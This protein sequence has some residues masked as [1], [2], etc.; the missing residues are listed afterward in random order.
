MESG[1]ESFDESPPRWD[2]RFV[3]EL[4][5]PPELPEPLPPFVFL[6]MKK[7]YREAQSR[8]ERDRRKTPR[9]LAVRVLDD[10]VDFK[11][12]MPMVTVGEVIL[13]M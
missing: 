1:E 12:W 5:L 2:L 4:F 3:L 6:P 13:Y 9:E 8:W 10:S 11:S 7:V